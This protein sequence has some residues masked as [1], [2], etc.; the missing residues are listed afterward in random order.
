MH[1][2]SIRQPFAELILRGVKT[3]AAAGNRSRPTKMIGRRFC[4]YVPRKW[5]NVGTNR[6]YSGGEGAAWA[7]V[8][9]VSPLPAMADL[10]PDGRGS[11]K[12]LPTGVIV[13]SAVI[14]RCSPPSG[15]GEFGD[16]WQWHLK[17]VR[18]YK[19][20]RK[21]QR[22]VQPQPVWFKPFKKAA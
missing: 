18:R 19:R 4:I 1:A 14:A 21:L 20:P 16:C 22:G 6:D 8:R 11:L 7:C 13:G 10:R 12:A 9:D 5:A 17:D 3:A 15:H 2:L